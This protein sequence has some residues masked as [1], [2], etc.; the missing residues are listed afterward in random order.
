ME[1]GRDRIEEEGIGRKGKKRRYG[2]EEEQ[3]GGS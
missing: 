3:R 1:G 2:R